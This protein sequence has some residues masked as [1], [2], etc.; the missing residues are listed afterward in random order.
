MTYKDIVEKLIDKYFCFHKIV[1]SDKA[2]HLGHT[3]GEPEQN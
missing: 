1:L 2:R 3:F